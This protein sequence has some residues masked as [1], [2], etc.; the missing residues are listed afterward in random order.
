MSR[1]GILQA[2]CVMKNDH[3]GI[4]GAPRRTKCALRIVLSR[5]RISVPPSPLGI[6][7]SYRLI[8]RHVNAG[9]I[10]CKAGATARLSSHNVAPADPDSLAVDPSPMS[11]PPDVIGPPD[12]I[13]GAASI[14][15]PIANRHYDSPTAS[16]VR[17]APVIRSVSRVTSVITVTSTC[18]DDD[19]KTSKQESCPFQSR[20][21]SV[22]DASSFRLP[23]INNVGFH[24]FIIRIR[25]SFH[26]PAANRSADVPFLCT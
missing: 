21:H 7:S 13:P 10:A 25:E 22:P 4:L 18:S 15:R 17:R 8:I 24:T 19:R 14:V 20:F 2:T 1:A 16:V 11:R 6:S 12:V 23:V 26:A 5:K 3:R 9:R